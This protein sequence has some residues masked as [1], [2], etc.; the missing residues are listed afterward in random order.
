L[1]ASLKR[2][3]I[4]YIILG[5][6][7]AIST[8]V[9]VVG[10][11][12]LINSSF[13]KNS[14]FISSDSTTTSNPTTLLSPTEKPNRVKIILTGDVMLGRSVMIE[15]IEQEDPLFPFRKVADVL[16]EV[17]LVFIN[18]ENP[19]IK[20]CPRHVGG[21]TFCTTYEIA[22]GLT[23]SGV[24]VVNLAN[25]HSGNYGSYGINET[26]NYLER[27]EILATGVGKLVTKEVNGT[28]FGFLGFEYVFKPSDPE[29][30]ELVKKSDST[31][32]ILIV[33]VHWGDE[34][35][36]TANQFQRNLAREFIKNGADVVVGHH[37]HWVQDSEIVDGVPVYYSLGNFVFDQMWSEETKKGAIVELI[38]E[39]GKFIE[40]RLIKT[41]IRERGQPEFVE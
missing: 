5:F 25:N 14:I 8:S 27:N 37:P 29:H 24:D 4:K 32:D 13:R 10:A 22:E 28:N 30:L 38:F 11:L 7:A 26:I 19:I 15:A 16:R 9:I 23:F 31:V 17:D 1:Y 21:F 18:L 40:D 41:Y 35:K 6:L 2:I 39:D 33:G 3:G 36:D 12:I 34:Y 20:D